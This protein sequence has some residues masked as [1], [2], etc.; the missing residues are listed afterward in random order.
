VIIPNTDNL[1]HFEP[2][3]FEWSCLAYLLETMGC[4]PRVYGS[5]LNRHAVR[6]R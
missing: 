1:K 3:K 2:W 6:W 4:V 5:A